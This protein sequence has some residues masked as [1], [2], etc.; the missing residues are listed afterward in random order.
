MCFLWRDKGE[1]TYNEQVIRF[2]QLH[3][4]SKGMAKMLFDARRAVDLMVNLKETDSSRIGAMGHS[5]GGK[6]A[7]YLGA[8]DD[9]V[10][11]IVSNEGGIG[12]NFS[13]WNDSW[14]LGKEIQNF[15]YQHHE[16]LALCAPRPFLLI[17]GDFADGVKS[18]PYINAVAPV[19]KL[20]GKSQNLKLFN[21]GQGHD[22]TPEAEKL[23]YDWI[24]EHL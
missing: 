23:T 1:R 21:H 12:I 17:G 16:L 3:P 22:V 20:Y 19:Y 7:L 5:L 10:K 13:N 18:I 6:E 15:N 9:R 14:Y 4:Q 8:F 2:H 24:I 11:V